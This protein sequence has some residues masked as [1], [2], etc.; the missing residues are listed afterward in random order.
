MS[1]YPETRQEVGLDEGVWRYVKR[2]ELPN[3]CCQNLPDLTQEFRAAAARLRHKPHI[4]RA[5]IRH[6][7]YQL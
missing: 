3:R 5:C 4:L 2:I 6:A 1:V 7:G